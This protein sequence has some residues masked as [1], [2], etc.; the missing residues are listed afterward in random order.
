MVVVVVRVETGAV[1]ISMRGRLGMA[2]VPRVPTMYRN[3]VG[4]GFL[5]DERLA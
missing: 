1:L 2:V 3:G 5:T 4:R